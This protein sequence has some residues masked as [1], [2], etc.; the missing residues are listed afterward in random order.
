VGYRGPDNK[1]IIIDGL[2]RAEACRREGI[3][4]LQIVI[5]EFGDLDPEQLRKEL[6]QASDQRGQN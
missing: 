4:D 3:N 2:Q 5:V 1:I 6:N